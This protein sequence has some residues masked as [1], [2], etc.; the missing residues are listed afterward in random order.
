MQ[1]QKL[2]SRQKLFWAARASFVTK[3]TFPVYSVSSIWR[4]AQFPFS[5]LI[6]KEKIFAKIILEIQHWV[7]ALS[8]YGMLIV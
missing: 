7:G 1:Q 3:S 2:Q 8:I 4:P 5:M 6:N